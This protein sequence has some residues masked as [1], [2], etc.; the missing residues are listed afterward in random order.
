L[1]SFVSCSSREAR[2][3]VS[4][5]AVNS[6]RR[7]EPTLPVTA[8]PMCNRA[9]A[10]KK[11]EVH[12]AWRANMTAALRSIFGSFGR[13]RIL[14]SPTPRAC[15]ADVLKSYGAEKRNSGSHVTHRS[16]GESGANLTCTDA[17]GYHP[18]TT[19]TRWVAL[20][21]ARGTRT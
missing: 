18:R 2:F 10:G 15:R 13:R 6:L 21:C 4:P 3:T 20:S 11:D 17:R 19:R 9:Y 12:A 7:G 16:S 14:S 1:C 5:I 8:S